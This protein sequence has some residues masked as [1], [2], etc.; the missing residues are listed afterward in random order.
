MIVPLIQ[1]L[2]DR[3]GPAT[4][5][6]VAALGATAWGVAHVPRSVVLFM[7]FQA[8]VLLLYF[9]RIPRGLKILLTAIA[10]GVLMPVLGTINAYYMEIAIQVGI[11]V[12]LALG[13][14]IVVGLAAFWTWATW[15]SSRWAPTRGRSSD[16]PRPT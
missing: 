3:P 7:L 12:A 16:R 5:I 1:R 15:P 10:L 9:A 8:S 2:L 6:V 11:F 13:L 14:N 4:I